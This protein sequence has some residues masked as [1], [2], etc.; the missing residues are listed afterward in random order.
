MLDGRIDNRD[1][2]IR[3]LDIEEKGIKDITDVELAYLSYLRWG[4]GCSSQLIGAF[5]L[6]IF[7]ELNNKIFLTRDHIGSKPI[8]FYK[9]SSRFIFSSEINGI[10]SLM[11]KMPSIN[12][13]R[14]TDYIVYLFGHEGQTFYEEIYKLPKASY[15][16][17]V[18]NEIRQVR[19]FQFNP[20]Y[21]RKFRSFEDCSEEFKELFV[22]VVKR[23]S[24]SCGKIGSRLSGGIDSSSITSILAKET[25]NPINAY[26]AIFSNLNQ[27]DFNKTDERE[28]MESVANLGNIDHK[29]VEIDSK[30][31]NIFNFL[32][33]DNN[34]YGEVTP[35][36][37][38]YMEIAIL[39]RA[40]RDGVRV[41][42]DGFDGDSVLSYGVENLYSLARSRKFSLLIQ[43]A[44]AFNPNLNSFKILKNYF[45]KPVIPENL[46]WFYQIARGTNH[47]YTKVKLLNNSLRSDYK[48]YSPKQNNL[49]YRRSNSK[50]KTTQQMHL[51]SL[52]WPLW[53][54]AMEFSEL[55]SSRYGIEERYPFFDR[56][57]MEFCLSVPSKYRLRDGISRFYFRES[58]KGYLPQNVFNRLTKANI[59]PVAVNALRSL[60]PKEI[61]RRIFSNKQ[62]EEIVI[63]KEV[64]K[65][66]IK[67]FFAGLKNS[68]LSQTIFQLI[69]L[70]EWL[71]KS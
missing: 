44:K 35:H 50:P 69:S 25:T 46:L 14:V 12:K 9:D 5:V 49:H 48:I 66:V 55:D 68:E 59:S 65:F 19:Y 36:A 47:F 16:T 56:R 40:S 34:P 64:D 57:I 1:E 8:Y 20:E 29:Y 67:P 70:S 26:S 3:K 60:G 13:K 11:P 45:L 4:E 39:E 2:L 22:D 6:L 18:G 54:V 31:T 52:D 51:L 17:L 38:R 32:N 58:M 15:L 30:K 42:F 37:N 63:K 33:Y 24:R 41:L 61:N 28:Y 10:L 62:M 21:E 27:E 43:Q 23:Q 7:E 53:E 71:K